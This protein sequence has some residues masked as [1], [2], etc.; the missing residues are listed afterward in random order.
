MDKLKTFSKYAFAV[1]V[2][3]FIGCWLIY[4]YEYSSND[5]LDTFFNFSIA[6]IVG[7]IV[8]VC[9]GYLVYKYTKKDSKEE[10]IN[11]KIIE[12]TEK[13]DKLVMSKMNDVSA[14]SKNDFKISIREIQNTSNILCILCQNSN[15]EEKANYIDDNLS[16]LEKYISEEMEGIEMSQIFNSS[17]RKEKIESFIKNVTSKCDDIIVSIYKE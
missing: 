9:I 7:L 10:K 13:I 15:Y 2:G 5:F 6:D 14:L 16:N 12:L 11:N 1:A 17:T 4:N 8:E 3:F